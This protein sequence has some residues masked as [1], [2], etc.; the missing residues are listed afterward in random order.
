MAR[1]IDSKREQLTA[2]E[3]RELRS[4]L[5]RRGRDEGA[6]KRMPEGAE[7]VLS[8]AQQRLWFLDQFEPGSDEY[9]VPLGLR[10]SGELDTGALRR[11]LERVVERHRALRTSFWSERGQPRLRVHER[12]EIPWQ[13]VDL[14]GQPEAEAERLAAE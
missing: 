4:R 5:R 10:L 6:L 2:A 7:P 8:F 11:A 13:E 12:V 14:R 9:N 1:N 3:L